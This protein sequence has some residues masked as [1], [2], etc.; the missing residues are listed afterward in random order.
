MDPE[1]TIAAPE[2][3]AGRLTAVGVVVSVALHLAGYGVIRAVDGEREHAP[4]TFSTIDIDVAPVAPRAED[5]PPEQQVAATT[6]PPA[7]TVPVAPPPVDPDG[8]GRLDAG[9]ADASVPIDAGVPI[10][11]R[12]PRDARPRPDAGVP[13]DA[14]L[15]ADAS[16]DAALVATTDD[17]GVGDG[18]LVAEAA[19]GGVGDAGAVATT[20]EADPTG[21]P[22]KT[23]SG[24]AANLLAYAPAGHVV[25]LLARLDRLR[26]TPWA[27]QVE[28]MLAPLPD[29]GAL[30]GDQAV[31]ISDVFDTLVITSSDPD[32]VVAT[33]I[34]ARSRLAPAELRDLL[35]QPDARVLWT[36]T[37]G[38]ALG[39]RQPSP[40]LLPGDARV[41]L[42][43]APG[44]TTLA[45]PTDLAG[46]LQPATIGLDHAFAAPDRL[47]AWL[48]RVSTIEAESGSPDG[49]ALM[50]TAADMFPAAFELPMI[51]V[52]IPAPDRA[53]LTLTVV[54]LG[55]EVRG[56][57][58]YADA[59]AAATASDAIARARVLLLDSTLAKL[60][61]R[62]MKAFHAIEGLDVRP[63]GSRVAFA[64]SIS[65]PD[66]QALLA[67]LGQM[68]AAHFDRPRPRPRP[69][70]RP[71]A[72]AP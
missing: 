18:G 33:T 37:V 6:P 27:D 4:P 15:D 65:G 68:V 20:G 62:R 50:L 45:Q 8:V 17:G 43:W 47:P 29:H 30:I 35:D 51:D 24:T 32:V 9:V 56:S 49:P 52:A 13:L 59:G 69:A 66:A 54:P 22:A 64:T 36:P 11:A 26:G 41:F 1:P 60:A 28:A 3:R 34:V 53:T 31:R 58:R 42:T 71:D 46:L 72:G 12:P 14:G 5:L 10:D 44:W 57:L 38:G 63:T 48:A 16:T 21:T 7:D 67:W 61:L 25:T 55:F 40:R 23:S 2:P 19:D 39:R 70:P